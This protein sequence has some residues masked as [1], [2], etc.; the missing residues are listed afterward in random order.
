MNPIVQTI[1]SLGAITIFV[2]PVTMAFVNWLGG[3]GVQGRW[4]LVSSM[5]TGLVIGGGLAYITLGMTS[6]V[7]TVGASS[8][9]GLT[10]GLA[11]S[12]VY[13]AL[14]ESTA[15]GVRMAEARTLE[16]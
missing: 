15:Q 6:T 5:V 2:L 13:D 4:K 7:V 14:K 1:T 12:G 3:L 11:T 16:K 8:L 10:V 9:Y